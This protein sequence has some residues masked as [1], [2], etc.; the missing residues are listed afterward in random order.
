M[1]R[2]EKMA[3]LVANIAEIRGVSSGRVNLKEST[4]LTS[5]GLDSLDI[6][7]LQLFY[8]EQTGV[9]IPDSDRRISTIKDLLDILP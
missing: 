3:L 1:T 5:L 9:M 8:E 4:Q 7:E 6:V 2:S